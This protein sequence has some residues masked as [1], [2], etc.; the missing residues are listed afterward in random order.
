MTHES[1][2]YTFATF[3]VL[4]A[5]YSQ[6]FWVFFCFHSPK[7]LQNLSVFVLVFP[8]KKNK[9]PSPFS[10]AGLHALNLDYDVVVYLDTDMRV[11]GDLTPIF[12]DG[13]SAPKRS[14][15]VSRHFGKNMQKLKI[16]PTSILV[17]TSSIFKICIFLQTKLLKTSGFVPNIPNQRFFYNHSEC[18][19][20]FSSPPRF[21]RGQEFFL[22]TGSTVAPLDGGFFAVKPS[23]GHLGVSRRWMCSLYAGL[24]VV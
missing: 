5:R 14:Q 20:P 19:R 24:V 6:F 18:R 16:E 3:H 1:H 11:V 9:P 17:Q 8:Q 23:G 22:S 10:S 4:V 2:D 7:T 15:A 13:S 21:S 12:E